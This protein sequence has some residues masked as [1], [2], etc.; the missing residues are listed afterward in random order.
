MDSMLTSSTRY[1]L[2]EPLPSLVGF[3]VTAKFCQSVFV[4]FTKIVFVNLWR[5]CVCVCVVGGH[6]VLWDM[7][8]MQSLQFVVN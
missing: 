8:I 5:L 6:N 2:A 3:N 1:L 4:Y 7:T